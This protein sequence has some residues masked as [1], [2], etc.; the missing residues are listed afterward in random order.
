LI[1]PSLLLLL[2]I[3]NNAATVVNQRAVDALINTLKSIFFG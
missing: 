2:M 3:I 1:G